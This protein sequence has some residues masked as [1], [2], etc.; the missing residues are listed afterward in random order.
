M[1]DGSYVCYEIQTPS[2]AFA[3]KIKPNAAEECTATVSHN[4]Q[5][6]EQDTVRLHKLFPQPR[7][8]LGHS[9]QDPITKVFSQLLRKPTKL[10]ERHLTTN[11]QCLHSSL[12]FLSFHLSLC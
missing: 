4:T 3:L 6:L 5:Y 9:L 1:G 10:L 2:S 11:L 12:W 7:S 8:F